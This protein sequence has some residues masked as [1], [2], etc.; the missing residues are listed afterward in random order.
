MKTKD[1]KI[2]ELAYKFRR[3]MEKA[4]H[5]GEFR[6][7]VYLKDFPVGSCG[8]TCD[9]LGVYLNDNGFSTY[10]ISASYEERTHAW[11]V[12]DDS[13]IDH[14]AMEELMK[15]EELPPE[16]QDL[17]KQYG[18]DCFDAT[19]SPR[20]SEKAFQNGLI[21]D[22]TG[23]QFGWVPVYVGPKARRYSV[24]EQMGYYHVDETVACAR[25]AIYNKII[26][27]IE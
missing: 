4:R 1:R 16:I 2:E 25:D 7:E 6:Y 24:Y 14:E 26:S 15:Q 13:R 9:Y 8:V 11:L 27:Y 17:Y 23:D 20:L 22:I 5:N 18:G 19:L 12:L 10:Q 3:A 21:I